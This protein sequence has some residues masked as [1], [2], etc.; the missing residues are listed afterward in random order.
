MIKNDDCILARSRVHEARND[1]VS[2]VRVHFVRCRISKPTLRMMLKLT[3]ALQYADAL[4]YNLPRC[5]LPGF[6]VV[7]SFVD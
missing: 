1:H 2:C 5:T 4:S 3:S 6:L 7:F